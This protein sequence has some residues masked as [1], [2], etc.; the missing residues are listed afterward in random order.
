MKFIALKDLPTHNAGE[1]FEANEDVGRILMMPGIDAAKPVDE[2][3]PLP[4]TSAETPSSETEAPNRRR[5][6]RRDLNADPS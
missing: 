5:Y 6:R 4:E 1:V 2:S 3:T